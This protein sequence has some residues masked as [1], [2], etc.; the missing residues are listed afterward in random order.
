MDT[1][2]IAEAPMRSRCRVEGAVRSVR[3][4]PGSQVPVFEVVVEDGTGRMVGAFWGR[5]VI[6]GIEPGTRIQ[7]EGTPRPH[8]HERVMA[9][10]LYTLLPPAGA[11]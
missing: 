10:P 9:N 7:M 8:E 11:H 5:R 1:V 3:V 6:H 2:P 4:R